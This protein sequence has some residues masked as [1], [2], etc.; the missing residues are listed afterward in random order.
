MMERY[1]FTWDESKA[2][3]NERKHGVSFVEAQTVFLD[4]EALFMADSDHSEEE[5]RF[6]L[7]GL[8]PKL[9]IVMVCH[10]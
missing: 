7:L 2:R 4:D 9:R 10:A 8:S 1:R 6:L 3:S 5:E